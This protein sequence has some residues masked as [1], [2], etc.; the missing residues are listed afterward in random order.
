[1]LNRIAGAV[2]EG[3]DSFRQIPLILQPDCLNAKAICSS[4]KRFRF[5]RPSS[6]GFTQPWTP[7]TWICG[8]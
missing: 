5:N 3:R 8:W 2:Q 1:V 7:S 4:E 6:F